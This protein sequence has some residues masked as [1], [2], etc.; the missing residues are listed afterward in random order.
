MATILR[1]TDGIKQVTKVLKSVV[2]I[3]SV[4]QTL[5]VK[6]FNQ[7]PLTTKNWSREMI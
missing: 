4:K 5:H 2:R 3:E 6:N 1:K 7:D